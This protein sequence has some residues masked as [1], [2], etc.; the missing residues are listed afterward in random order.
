MIH[1]C[2]VYDR[3][4]IHTELYKKS[5]VTVLTAVRRCFKEF[6]RNFLKHVT[7]VQELLIV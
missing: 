1:D 3:K 4:L 2:A 5:A 7:P 6:P